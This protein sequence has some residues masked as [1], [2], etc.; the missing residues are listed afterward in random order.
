MTGGTGDDTFIIR[1]GDGNT[2]VSLA[3]IITDFTDGE[4]LLGGVGDINNFSQLTVTQGTGANTAD[5]VISLTTTGEILA[6]LENFTH[7]DF[8]ANDFI[9][10]DIT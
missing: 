4:D 10:L 3:D 2:S 8:D 5:T 1:S 9:Q 7:T 6:V